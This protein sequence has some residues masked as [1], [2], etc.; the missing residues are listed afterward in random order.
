ML[1]YSAVEN[2]KV[3]LSYKKTRCIKLKPKVRNEKYEV[4]ASK[5]LLSSYDRELQMENV[6]HQSPL[7]IV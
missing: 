7:L 2:M 1:Q 3:L 5:K 4:K 6:K